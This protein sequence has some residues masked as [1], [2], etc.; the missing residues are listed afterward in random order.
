M[1]IILR[2]VNRLIKPLRYRVLPLSNFQ[3]ACEAL[4]RSNRPIYFIQVGAND[5]V[6]F[7]DLYFTVTSCRW[8]GLVIEPLPH[9]YER[10]VANYQDHPA[11]K[12]LNIAIH[13]TASNAT[14]YHV[15]P[16]SLIKYPDYAAGIPSMMKE[17]LLKN[18]VADED[19]E[20]LVVPCHTLTE[21]AMANGLA[22][23]DVLQIDTEGFDYEVLRSMDFEVIKPKVIKFEWMNLTNDDKQS[24][25]NLLKDEGYAL[26]L[27]HGATDC[28]A[29]IN[30][31]ML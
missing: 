23:V 16:E 31:K 18:N 20:A 29:V 13:P 15:K 27:E 30:R 19:I 8:A 9:F 3:L 24:A 26:W 25:S 28:V 10:L 2:V 6:R 1:G 17:H 21:V 11:V 12:P 7:D 14:I 22:N 5:G 4:I